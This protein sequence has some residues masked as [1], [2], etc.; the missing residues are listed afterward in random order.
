MLIFSQHRLE[1]L[2]RHMQV[3][4]KNAEKKMKINLNETSDYHANVFF[5]NIIRYKL[6]IKTAAERNA[7]K[8]DHCRVL[9]CGCC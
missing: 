9:Y 5:V 8:M 6:I 4:L 1:A 3:M 2:Y 7:G